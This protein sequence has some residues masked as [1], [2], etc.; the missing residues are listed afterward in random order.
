MAI[1]ITGPRTRRSLLAGALGGIAA[2]VTSTLTGAQRVLAE[3]DDGAP[4]AVGGAYSDVRSATTLANNSNHHS[5]LRAVSNGAGIGVEAYGFNGTG[6]EGGT[7]TGTGVHGVAN[8]NTGFTKGVLGEAYSPHGVGVLGNNY[9][10]SGW[11]EGIQGTTDSPDGWASVGWATRRGTALVGFS[12]PDFPYTA[13]PRNTGVFGY[14]ESGRGGVFRGPTAQV[15]LIPSSRASHP[16]SGAI[17][18]LFLDNNRRLWF[19]KG[20]TTWKQIA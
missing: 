19:C 1:D 3:G 20:G 7:G 16:A 17:G 6:V 4:V 12:G 9:A 10:T 15:R 11:A 8:Y 2:V 14:A 18:D 13:I 5:V